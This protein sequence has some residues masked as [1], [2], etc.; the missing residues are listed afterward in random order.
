[1]ARHRGAINWPGLGRLAPGIRFEAISRDGEWTRCCVEEV[2]RDDDGVDPKVLVSFTTGEPER[3]IR[4]PGASSRLRRCQL[5]AD[6]DSDS[7]PPAMP[8]PLK[9]SEAALQGSG[10]TSARRPVGGASQAPSSQHNATKQ[11]QGKAVVGPAQW[12]QLG[13]MAPDEV[14]MFHT[15]DEVKVELSMTGYKPPVLVLE[16]VLVPEEMRGRG[17]FRRLLE[18]CEQHCRDNSYSLRVSEIESVHVMLSCW[19]RGYSLSAHTMVGPSKAQ[20]E[21]IRKPEVGSNKMCCIARL[22][23]QGNLDLAERWFNE[24][25]QNFGGGTLKGLDMNR[26]ADELRASTYHPTRQ[27]EP[28][29]Q[30]HYV[31]GIAYDLDLD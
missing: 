18:E 9:P 2:D 11:H 17:I 24:G 1:M 26:S 12:Q 29:K 19:R 8:S 20:M 7:E 31:D 6:S 4:L 5:K 15:V 23:E 25:S 10:E 22:V 14:L 27:I 13:R 28:P 16:N 21:L 3:W 30:L